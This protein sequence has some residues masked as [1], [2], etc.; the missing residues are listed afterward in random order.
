MS[1]AVRV[2]TIRPTTLQHVITSSTTSNY[3]HTTEGPI[4][5]HCVTLTAPGSRCG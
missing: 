2:A 4:S 5:N 3:N 1:P